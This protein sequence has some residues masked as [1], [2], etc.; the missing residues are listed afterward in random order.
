[1]PELTV[2]ASF[3]A[4]LATKDDLAKHHKWLEDRLSGPKALSDVDD[5]STAVATLPVLITFPRRPVAGR[6]W[7]INWCSVFLDG[8]VAPVNNLFADLCIG[9]PRLAPGL[10]DVVAPGIAVPGYADLR[11]RIAKSGQQ[12][13]L[14][15]Y[16]SGTI[17]NSVNINATMGFFDWEDTPQTVATL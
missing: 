15:V 1:M 7:S 3:L 5:G 11:H 13:Y 9:T 10:S 6:L 8:Q 17:S 2:E 12:I 16:G 4:D 14:I